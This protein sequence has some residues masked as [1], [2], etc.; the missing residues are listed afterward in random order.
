MPASKNLSPGLVRLCVVALIAGVIIGFIG[1]G[2]R[3]CLSHLDRWRADMLDW[4]NTLPGPGWL[5]PIVVTAAGAIAAAAIVRAMP[6]ASGSGIQ[7]VEAVQRGEASP[8]PLLLLPAKF[9]GGLIAIGAGLVLGREGPTV[10]MGAAVGAAAARQAGLDDRD[11]REMQTSVGGAGLAVAFSA[12]IGGALFVLEEVAKS[13]RMRIVIPTLVAVAAAVACSRLV[14]G[15]GSDFHVGAVDPPSIV[16][17]PVFIVFGL[18]T[19]VM[20]GVYSRMI[21]GALDLVARFD[22]V[23][24]VVKAGIAGA[25]IGALLAIDPLT[26]GGGDTV[27]QKVLDGGGLALPLVAALFLIRFIAGPLSYAAAT[28]GGLFAPLLALGALWG[29]LF[30]ALT[31]AVLPGQ[32]PPLTVAMAIVGMSALFGA[33]VRAPVT[34]VVLVMEMTATTTVTVPMLAATAAAVLVAQLVG[35]PPIYDL[36]RERMLASGIDSSAAP[37]SADDGPDTGRNT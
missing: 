1:G 31:D 25:I 22:H 28:P 35:S 8:P 36:L 17:L 14:I 29:M 21:L 37:S 13:A 5:I 19:G 32:Q 6:L 10:H 4:V 16:L 18:V 24:V 9:V 12:P 27:A 23:P 11:A 2:F 34:G 33:V 15:D 30:A 20:G 7:H 26:A 3:W